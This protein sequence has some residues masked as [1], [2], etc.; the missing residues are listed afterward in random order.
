MKKEYFDQEAYDYIESEINKTKINSIFKPILIDI[1]LRRRYEYQLDDKYFHRDVKS[2]IGNVR[3]IYLENLPDNIFGQFHHQ[4]KCIRINKKKFEK[5]VHDEQGVEVLLEVIC[6]E[7]VHAMNSDEEIIDRT[8]DENNQILDNTGI[9]EIF[10]EKEADRMVC[11][12][13]AEEA[14]NYHNKTNA[15]IYTTAYVNAIAAA[16][17]VKEKDLLS[18]ATKGNPELFEL[19]NSN[20]KSKDFSKDIFEQICFNLNL[21]HIDFYKG[22]E[23]FLQNLDEVDWENLWDSLNFMYRDMEQILEYRIQNLEW[24]NSEDLQKKLEDIKLSQNAVSKVMESPIIRTLA[25][26]KEKELVAMHDKTKVYAKVMSIEEIIK[27]QGKDSNELISFV[28]KAE[29]VDGILEFMKE[30]GMEINPTNVA[31]M[32]EFELSEQKKDEWTKE[33]CLDGEEWDNTELINY[34]IANKE[35]IMNARRR[36][37]FTDKIKRGIMKI[38]KFYDKIFS[39]PNW[40]S[41]KEPLLLGERKERK[42][43]RSKIMGFV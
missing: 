39:F 30:N 42:S 13:E 10:V 37:S 22:D 29:S 14:F 32:P 6:H 8:F 43:G 33:F 24:D 21:A 5:N 38:Y 34:M 25:K 19:L 41:K 4:K 2:F 7:C 3:D 36:E 23:S 16:F 12:R 35:E 31:L 20:I 11:N 27:R 28:Q 18:A 26:V 17:G 1:I 9:R 15:Y 40:Y